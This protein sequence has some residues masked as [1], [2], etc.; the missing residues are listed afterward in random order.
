MTAFLFYILKVMLCSG[1]LL[2]YYQLALRNRLYH[3]WNRFYLLAAVVLSLVLPLVQFTLLF[4]NEEQTDAFLLLQKMQ[5]ANTYLDEVV[6]TSNQHATGG[7]WF[8]T[9]YALICGLFLLCFLLS[10]V[11][12]FSLIQQHQFE[13]FQNV[14]FTQ[15]T[16]PGTPFSFFRYIFWNKKIPMQSAAGQQ[17]FHHELIHAKENHTLD[18]LFMQ[19]VLSFSWFNPFFWLIRKELC[20]IH[21]AIAD[22]KAVGEQD[23]S[24]LAALILQTAYPQ[25]FSTLTNPFFQTSIKRRLAMLTKNSHANYASRIIALP[26]IAC[27]AFAFSVRTKGAENGLS[28]TQQLSL[29]SESERSDTIPKTNKSI[30]AIDIDKKTKTATLHYTDG[31]MATMPEKEA[32]QQKHME[33]KVLIN[34]KNDNDT[35]PE[36]PVDP[37]PLYMLDGEEFSGDLNTIDPFNIESV[38]VLKDK[39]ATDKYGDK[40]K[41]GVVEIILKKSDKQAA[42][43]KENNLVF[44]QTETPASIDKQEWRAFLEKNLQPLIVN[45]AKNGAKPGSYTVNIRFLV[46][47]DGSVSDFTAL[48]DPGYDLVKQMLALMHHSPNWKPAEQNGRPVNA[49]HTQPITFV[50]Q[51]Q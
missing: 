48:N 33:K 20:F 45:A 4:Q 39:S 5:N 25:Q 42:P 31:T 26:V 35:V 1:V 51:E 17:I 46:K 43:K 2:V 12:M 49:Y 7:V 14:C 28:N 40:G 13:K 6:I 15:S 23:V 37:K 11:K 22:Q 41:N 16:V 27:V 3:Q 50:I 18:K 24:V 47:T 21:E 10:L 30:N 32:F 29:V 36:K 38:N 34:V 9:A 44:E 8:W 19:V